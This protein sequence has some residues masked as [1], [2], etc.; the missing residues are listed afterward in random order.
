MSPASEPGPVSPAQEARP[1][2]PDKLPGAES[3]ES[4]LTVLVAMGANA[5]IAVAKTVAA[6]L[7]GSASMVAE[8]AHSWTDTFNEVFLLIAQRSGSRPRDETH[9]QGYGRDTYI[10]SMFAAV[11]L[12]TAGASVS[13]IHGV[14]QLSAKSEPG[15]YMINYLVLA[16]SFVFEGT[17][18]LQALRQTRGNAADAGIGSLSFI[19]QTSNPT[20]RAVFLEDAVA[21]VGLVLAGIGIGLHQLTGHEVF[22]ALGSIAVGLLLGAA[23][24]FLI[25]RNRQ[26]LVGQ[27]VN[28]RIWNRALETLMAAPEIDHVT[29]LHLEYVGPMRFFVVAAVDLTG[30]DRETRLAVRLRRLERELESR[31]LIE[32]AV[33]TLAT[34]DEPPLG[35]REVPPR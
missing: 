23:A 4:V 31:D 29:Y 18:F 1:Q 25:N 22:D 7:T 12:F 26:F 33:F 27:S 34:P 19:N 35:P 6:L 24:V 2:L 16:V 13:I 21:L 8:A 5:I 30:D 9:P 32:D 11:G 3:S 17:S 20:L 10:W 15:H 14:Q 28:P